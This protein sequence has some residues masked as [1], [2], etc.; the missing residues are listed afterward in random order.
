MVG[1]LNSHAVLIMK[2]FRPNSCKEFSS[3]KIIPDCSRSFSARSVAGVNMIWSTLK[4]SRQLI[5]LNQPVFVKE[6]WSNVT[7]NGFSL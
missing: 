7:T 6:N 2:A 1:I 3:E 4:V 5:M